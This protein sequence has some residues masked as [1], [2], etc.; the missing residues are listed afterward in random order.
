MTLQPKNKNVI[1]INASKED[2]DFPPGPLFS[3]GGPKLNQ[4]EKVGEGRTTLPFVVFIFVSLLSHLI[5]RGIK[6]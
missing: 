3:N 4:I 2:S 6:T 1:T 5:M